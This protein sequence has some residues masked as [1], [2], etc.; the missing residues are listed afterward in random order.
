MVG[1]RDGATEWPQ[2]SSVSHVG[3]PAVYVSYSPGPNFTNRRKQ[4]AQ[5]S[6]TH[7]LQNGDCFSKQRMLK[8][9]PQ[10]PYILGSAKK[11]AK[12]DCMAKDIWTVT[13]S[14]FLWEIH[15]TCIPIRHL[16]PYPHIYMHI[17]VH[18]S[19][20]VYAHICT[21]VH[22]YMVYGCICI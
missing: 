22:M 19:I 8:Q 14:V 15:K 17:Y 12:K 3:T 4:L 9:T 20:F 21:Y 18:T 2:G 11:K 6:S 5:T 10:N 13:Y 7:S 16:L 1:L